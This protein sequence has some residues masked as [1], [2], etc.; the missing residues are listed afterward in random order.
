[1]LCGGTPKK[2]HDRYEQ[3]TPANW[4]SGKA[5]PFLLIQGETDALVSTSETYSFWQAQEAHKVP[6]SAFLSLPLVQHAFDILPSLTA[7]CIIPTIERY[8][9]M[10]HENHLYN[11][12]KK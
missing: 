4:I 2:Q 1:M 3:I 10:L 6:N 11:S 7:Q 8:L 9:I 5:P 12:G